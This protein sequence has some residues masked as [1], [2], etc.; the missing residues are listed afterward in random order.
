[1][2]DMITI[3]EFC[4]PASCLCSTSPRTMAVR[5]ML[6]LDGAAHGL[7]KPGHQTVSAEAR[8]AVPRAEGLWFYTPNFSNDDHF[9]R[10][11]CAT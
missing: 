9:Q 2:D 11:R 8:H 4:A 7:T 10:W 3:N 6:I 5:P 1:M